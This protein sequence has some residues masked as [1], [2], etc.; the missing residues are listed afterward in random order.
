MRMTDSEVA[1][2]WHGIAG[3][4]VTDHDWSTVSFCVSIAAGHELKHIAA[5]AGVW[6]QIFKICTSCQFSKLGQ[7][8][9]ALPFEPSQAKP[10]LGTIVVGPRRTL[11]GRFQSCLVP[12][13]PVRA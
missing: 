10:R 6:K 8:A 11:A 3:L 5:L 2:G 12:R 4:H 1:L 9:E 7:P 13:T